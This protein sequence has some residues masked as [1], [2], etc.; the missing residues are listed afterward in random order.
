MVRIDRGDRNGRVP[1]G[2]RELKGLIVRDLD[3]R[4]QTSE[5]SA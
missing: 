3:L 2:S 4:I 5:S 1:I